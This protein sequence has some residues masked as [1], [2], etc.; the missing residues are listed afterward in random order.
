MAVAHQERNMERMPSRGSLEIARQSRDVFK[1]LG[2]MLEC[3]R[4][5]M[6]RVHYIDAPPGEGLARMV[7]GVKSAKDSDGNNYA[8]PLRMEEVR[9]ALRTENP[10]NLAFLVEVTREE[11]VL[12]M[13]SMC[14]DFSTRVFS[15]VSKD[16]NA[17]D[18]FVVNHFGEGRSHDNADLVEGM[19]SYAARVFMLVP[20]NCRV[21]GDTEV[22]KGV[23]EG[24]LR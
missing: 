14:A 3:A 11:A 12:Q 24:A 19:H 13:G 1:G 20:V 8:V 16:Q 7:V 18:P 6:P 10:G 17:G 4:F 2:A 5:V 23:L 9:K 21:N 15:L 22:W